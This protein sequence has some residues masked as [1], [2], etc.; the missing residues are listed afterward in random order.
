MKNLNQISGDVDLVGVLVFL[1]LFD[2]NGL[3]FYRMF[4]PAP[5]QPFEFTPP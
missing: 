3:G 4:K 1:E 5:V 2:C